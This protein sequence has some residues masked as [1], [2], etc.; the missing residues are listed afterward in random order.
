MSYLPYTVVFEGTEQ[1]T[2]FMYLSNPK[3]GD[4]VKVGLL[5]G[6]ELEYFTVTEVTANVVHLKPI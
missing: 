6:E 2:D 3:V 4:V 5:S 1:H